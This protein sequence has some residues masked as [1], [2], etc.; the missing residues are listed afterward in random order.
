MLPLDISFNTPETGIAGETIQVDWIGP[1]Y[2]GDFISVPEFVGF[3]GLSGVFLFRLSLQIVC[4]H[5][6]FFFKSEG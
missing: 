5:G 1:D 2:A 3:V 6:M 4:V